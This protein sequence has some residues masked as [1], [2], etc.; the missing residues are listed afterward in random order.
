[1]L[2]EKLASVEQAPQYGLQTLFGRCSPREV[3]AA[4]GVLG[5]LGQPR[6]DAQIE[7]LDPL[8]RVF[9]LAVLALGA[10][11][12]IIQL[13]DARHG[14]PRPMDDVLERYNAELDAET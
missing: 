1:M 10:A 7:L 4:G 5:R 14:G 6:E 3:L 9:R 13:V 8:L 2:K 12:R 11:A